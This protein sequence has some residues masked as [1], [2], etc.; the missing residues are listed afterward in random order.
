[1]DN[2][3]LCSN[4]N[5]PSHC[6]NVLRKFELADTLHPSFFAL[7]MLLFGY[8][9][10]RS[11]II[12]RFVLVYLFNRYNFIPKDFLLR[13]FVCNSHVGLMALSN[14]AFI[15]IHI[16]LLV[17]AIDQLLQRVPFWLLRDNDIQ[18]IIVMSLNKFFFIKRKKFI[19]SLIH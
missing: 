4:I 10:R 7:W 3:R 9:C 13:A 11:D 16:Y 2:F 19:I 17:C 12:W 1:M 5:F 8:G 18:I 14:D 15:F 6:T